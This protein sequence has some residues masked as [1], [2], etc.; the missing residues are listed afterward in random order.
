MSAQ[1]LQRVLG[2]KRYQTVWTMLHKLRRAMVRLGR[3]QLDG[4][5]EVDETLVGGEKHGKTGRGAEGK[6]LVAIAAEI[7]GAKIGRIRMQC[8]PQASERKLGQFI[9]RNI[10]EGST[11]VTDGWRGYSAAA[12][13]GYTHKTV[14]GESLGE[15]EVLPRVH[16]V[17]SLL[18][19]WLLG[20]HHGRVTPKHLD[21][22]LDEFTFRFNRRTSQFR[23][24]LFYRLLQNAVTMVPPTG[25]E[26]TH[27][28]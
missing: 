23:G 17:A 24:L 19:R 8:I 2:L 26:I 28:P 21:F 6:T 16:R 11:V 9:R 18:K 25:R 27:S 5:V 22:Y 7:D 4:K 10:A 1:G 12:L 13:A 20:I 3:T 14:L 15:K